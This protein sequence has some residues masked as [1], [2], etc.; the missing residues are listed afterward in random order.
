M[1]HKTEPNQTECKL[2]YF[3]LFGSCG[4]SNLVAYLIQS[5]PYKGTTVIPLKL[6]VC[7]GVRAFFK[8][9]CAELNVIGRLAFYDVEDQQ[10]SH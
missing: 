8:C 3:V 6:W 7:K 2:L 5:F 4:I 1:C 10:V 9:I